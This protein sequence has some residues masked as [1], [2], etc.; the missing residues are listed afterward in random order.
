M[1][2]FLTYIAAVFMTI[3]PPRY[4][5]DEGLRGPAMVS[6]L[7]QV[8]LFLFVL[9]FRAIAWIH[10]RTDIDINT[11]VAVGGARNFGSGIFLLVEFWMQPLHVFMFYLVIEGVIRVLAALVGHQVIGTLPLYPIAALHNFIDKRKHERELGDLIVDEVIRGGAQKGYDLKVY[12]CRPKLNWNPY[13][14]IEFEGEFY[15]MFKEEPGASPRRFIYYLRKNPV[16]RVVVVI[17]HYRMDSVLQT[18]GDKWAGA[19]TLWETMFP[20]WN[21]PPLTEDKVV[22]RAVPNKDYDLKIYCCR[23]K[24]DWNVDVTIDFEDQRYQLLRE[25]RGARPRPFIYYLRKSTETRPTVA[26]R[27]YKP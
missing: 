19:P 23:P 21:L 13:M 10:P 26:I 9:V 2:H 16:G 18:P 25:E 22:R 7:L 4:R 6:G 3:L 15:Q 14:T 11:A 8:L 12:S 20:N 1:K 27:R 24:R 5:P 17:D